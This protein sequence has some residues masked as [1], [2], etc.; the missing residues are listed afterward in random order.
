MLSDALS[1]YSL[2]EV[3]L[4]QSFSLEVIIAKRFGVVMPA[5][6]SWRGF[7]VVRKAESLREEMGE[8]Y[9]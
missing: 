6:Q 5:S 1:I 8:L 9:G 4:A 7:A 3:P 2:L